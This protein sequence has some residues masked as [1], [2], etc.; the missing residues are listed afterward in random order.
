MDAYVSVKKMLL[1]VYVHT[2]DLEFKPSIRINVFNALL[3]I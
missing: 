1:I 2:A 3:S